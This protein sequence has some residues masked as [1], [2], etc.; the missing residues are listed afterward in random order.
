MPYKGW[1]TLLVVAVVLPCAPFAS[2]AEDSLTLTSGEVVRGRIVSETAQEVEIEVANADRT[3][4]SKRA[5]PRTDVKSVQRETPEQAA[6]RT[7]FESLARYKLNPNSAYPT[8][9]YPAVIAAFD[10]FLSA[11][12]HSDHAAQIQALLADWKT[13]YPQAVLA[14]KKGLI[15]FHDRWLTP[16]QARE[17]A[18]QERSRQEALRNRQQEVNRT[19]PEPA[20]SQEQPPQNQ[21]SKKSSSPTTVHTGAGYQVDVPASAPY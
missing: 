16:E 21:P 12:P 15:K 7:A 13:E 18:E 2:Q 5:I 17:L 20:A 1:R 8:N 6:E 3:I 19:Q 11:H 9:Y 14:A 10:K 4:V